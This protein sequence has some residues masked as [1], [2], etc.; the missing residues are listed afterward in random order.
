ML[1]NFPASLNSNTI[2]QWQSYVIAKA[3]LEVTRMPT[4]AT[5]QV[6]VES[7]NCLEKKIII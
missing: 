2:K 4:M 7:F 1:R 3:C 5:S 6:L